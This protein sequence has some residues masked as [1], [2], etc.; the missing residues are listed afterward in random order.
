[1]E[2]ASVNINRKLQ[3]FLKNEYV[4]HVMC[5][6]L[7]SVLCLI[8]IRRLDY[9]AVLN[10]EFGYWGNAASIAGYDWHELISETPYYSLGYSLLLVPIIKILPTPELWYKAAIILNM[11][12]LIASY[13]LCFSFGEK[14]FPKIHKITLCFLSLITIIYPS[15]IIYGQVAWSETLLYFLM[16]LATYLLVKLNERFT[17][18]VLIANV[19]VLIYMYFVHA[20]SVGIIAVGVLCLFF[21]VLKHRKS[22]WI[23]VGIIAFIFSGYLF[24]S[25]IKQIQISGFWQNSQISNM[26]NVSI[27]LETVS[28]YL[29]RIFNNLK[30]FIESMGGKLFY[31]LIGTVF[32]LPVGLIQFIKETWNNIKSKHFFQDN[33]I[34]K[35]WCVFSLIA[36]F[37]LCSMQTMAWQD[38]KDLIVYS[39]YMENALGPFLFL[40]F[41]Y[42]IL[43]CKE[44]KYGV[45]ISAIAFACG[46]RKI[47]F[48]LKNSLGFFNSICSPIIGAFWDN[49]NDDVVK[50]ICW[51]SVIMALTFIILFASSFIKKY[52][53]KIIV[54]Y[55]LLFNVIIGCLGSRYMNDARQSFDSSTVPIM[56]SIR[57]SYTEN[58]IYYVKNPDT[59]PY[60]VNPKY[61]QFTIPSQSIHLIEFSDIEY[62]LYEG[63]IILTNPNDE[64]AESYLRDFEDKELVQSTNLLNVYLIK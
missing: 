60:S 52:R 35:F 42:T 12:L 5:I 43:K 4:F 13:F 14:L 36:M 23:F 16:W 9:I 51:I 41:T 27:N 55:I 11:I 53:V 19:L 30:L 58:D 6:A 56:L 20:R 3:K 38:R 17:F 37:I 48:R 33:Y 34:I 1:M 44:V 21:I 59:D 28:V 39:R 32:T 29:D 25:V 57:S 18:K 26:N 64:R 46:A 54:V 40:C 47:L 50:T 24:N 10:D 7:I 63:S 49:L 62:A 31:L 45:I 2:L 22:P 61:L 15:N 8:N